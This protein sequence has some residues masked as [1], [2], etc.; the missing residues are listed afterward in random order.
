MHTVLVGFNYKTT[1]V[2]SREKMYFPSNRLD[3]ALN[4]LLNYPAINECV[5][6]STCNRVEIYATSAEVDLA[7]ESIIKFLEDFHSLPQELFVPYIYK[8]RC[9][10]AVKHLFTVVSSLDSMIVGEYEILG[11]VKSAYENAQKANATKEFL[12]RLFQMAIVVGKRV[13]TE[14]AI[15]K[16]AIS[17]GSVAAGLIKEIFPDDL[18]LNVMLIGAGA[19]SELTANNLVSKVNCNI[20][21]S[22]RS[23]SKAEEFAQKFEAT[24]VDFEE[25]NNY[26]GNQ[27]VIV[28]STGSQD[29][30]ITAGEVES[31]NLKKGRKVAL[32]DLSVPRNIDPEL[33]KFE[34]VYLNT[35]DDL[36]SIIDSS[37]DERAREIV[38]AEGIIKD[39]EDKFI[40]WYNMQS[41]MPAMR[42]I[43]ME[44][45]SMQARLL[46]TY[47]A[48]LSGLSEVHREVVK[49][50]MESYSDVIIKTIMLNL[51]EVTD[52][53]TLH[54][55]GDALQKSFKMHSQ[56]DKSQLNGKEMHPHGEKIHHHHGEKMNPHSEAKCPYHEKVH[57]D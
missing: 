54:H 38:K 28:F 10:E 35:I 14:T 31:L 12:N 5:I 47:T 16:G 52:P 18:R 8:K 19:V 23:K 17:V 34:G 20:T 48:D 21:I 24:C 37:M 32:I 53:S 26:Y 42:Q 40:E 4:R 27:D 1:Q 3:E 49:R 39:Q 44:F 7:F 13:R 22:N 9:N 6:L 46:E 2:E 55:L 30:V 15:G 29:F 43:K 25:R 56:N 57:H 36:E 41:I 33:G 45:A 50:M 51:K 11:Q